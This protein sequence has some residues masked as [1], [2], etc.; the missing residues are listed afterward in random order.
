MPVSKSDSDICGFR[1]LTKEF[2]FSTLNTFVGFTWGYAYST[3]Y[4]F[5]VFTLGF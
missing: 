4:T 5:G 3:L 1:E 2:D